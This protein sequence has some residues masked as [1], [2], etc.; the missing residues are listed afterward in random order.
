MGDFHPLRLAIEN[1]AMLAHNIAAAHN[2]KANRAILTLAGDSITAAVRRTVTW[3][4]VAAVLTVTSLPVD[5][6]HN[7]KIDR[8][9]VAE[10]AARVL[11]GQTARV[12]W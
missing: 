5:I 6:R 7:T 11:S 8:T 3:V 1:H 12:P 10:W 2:G 9:A 4:P